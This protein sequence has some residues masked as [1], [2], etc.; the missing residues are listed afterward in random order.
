MYFSA[1]ESFN[2][3]PSSAAIRSFSLLN[4]WL[5]GSS[6]EEIFFKEMIKKKIITIRRQKI[7][8]AGKTRLF[9]FFLSKMLRFFSRKSYILK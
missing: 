9:V 4:A 1:D 5:L 8:M 3:A 2:V 7:E 6:V